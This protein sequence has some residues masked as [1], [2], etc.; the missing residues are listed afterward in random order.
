MLR[1]D[2]PAIAVPRTA[3]VRRA[4][5]RRARRRS[6]SAV[7]TDSLTA[8]PRIGHDEP[9]ASARRGL[10]R[11]PRFAATLMNR[12]IHDLLLGHVQRR[13][14]LDNLA[15]SANQDAVG[16]FSALDVTEEKI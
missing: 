10:L 8:C 3:P 9:G 12:R 7:V 5:L 2:V 6:Q 15:L 16:E 13:E 4:M 11:L 1:S 14:F